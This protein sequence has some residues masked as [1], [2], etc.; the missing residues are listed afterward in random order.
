LLSALRQRTEM[1][2]FT[3]PWS[4]SSCFWAVNY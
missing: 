1:P 4:I 2:I 3:Q